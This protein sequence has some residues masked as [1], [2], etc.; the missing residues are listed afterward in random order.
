M[1][2]INLFLLAAMIGIELILGIVVAPVIFYP[3][4]FIGEGVLSHFQSGL[5]MT[6][7]FIKMGYLLIFVSIFNLLFEIYSFIKE[8]MKFQIKFSKL[9]LSILILILSLAFILYFTNTIVEL[10]NLGEQATKSQEF[11]SIHNASEVVIKIILL[12]QVFLYFLSFKI[13]KKC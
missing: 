6:Q 11:L 10:Q 13:A 4:N 7:I 5:M 2:A 12:M 1:K 9:I 8:D 3:A